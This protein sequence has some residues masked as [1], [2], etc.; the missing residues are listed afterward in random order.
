MNKEILDKIIKI[1]IYINNDQKIFEYIWDILLKDLLIKYINKITI[2]VNIIIEDIRWENFPFYISI[3]NYEIKIKLINDIKIITN[4]T[5]I[6]INQ[7]KVLLKIHFIDNFIVLNI[8]KIYDIIIDTIL[9]DIIDNQI[10]N[11][12]QKTI[13][14]YS[15]YDIIL[16]DVPND[17][18]YIT[19]LNNNYKII[20][21]NKEYSNKTTKIYFNKSKAIYYNEDT[22]VKFYDNNKLVNSFDLINVNHFILL[23]NNKKYISISKNKVI[24]KKILLNIQSDNKCYLKININDDVKLVSV[25]KNNDISFDVLEYNISEN[26]KICILDIDTFCKE[27]YNFY[28]IIQLNDS[29]N[30]P[31]ENPICKIIFKYHTYP[32]HLFKLY[33]IKYTDNESGFIKRNLYDHIIKIKYNNI[34]PIIKDNINNLN[35][36]RFIYPINNNY[37]LFIEM[38]NK[39]SYL[40]IKKKIG[41]IMINLIDNTINNIKYLF[42]NKNLQIKS[43]ILFYPY[44]IIKIDMLHVK[45]INNIKYDLLS[46][47]DLFFDIN[48][49]NINKKTDIIN[50]SDESKWTF[51]NTEME[52]YLLY[53][54]NIIIKLYEKDIY[55]NNLLGKV[56]LTI[57]DIIGCRKTNII[58]KVINNIANISIKIFYNGFF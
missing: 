5:N 41:K 17:I 46:K 40:K 42:N 16:N 38:Y 27:E 35:D 57:D 6:N 54:D 58:N 44:H 43:D 18:I 48:I 32:P 51:S 34:Y 3:N 4:I 14:K 36:F 25:D 28:D 7:I 11:L 23:S 29:I 10:N 8:N 1:I 50:N 13:N 20:Y 15:N 9:Y 53:T 22:L 49:N 24:E 33:N 31:K 30:F 55:K 39:I 37:N 2:P 45:I 56:E 52:F 21:K 47:C 19:L 12:L 26:F